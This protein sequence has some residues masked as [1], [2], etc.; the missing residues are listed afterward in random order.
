MLLNNSIYEYAQFWFIY[1]AILAHQKFITV[2]FLH[3]YLQN[4]LNE[5]KAPTLKKHQLKTNKNLI[6]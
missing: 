5:R 1:Y 4:L 2:L 6:S 3:S